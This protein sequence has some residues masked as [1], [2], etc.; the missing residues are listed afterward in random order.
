MLKASIE[1]IL[2]TLLETL[3]KILS[4]EIKLWKAL[5]RIISQNLGSF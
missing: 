3:K 5:F 2:V 1:A 4:V